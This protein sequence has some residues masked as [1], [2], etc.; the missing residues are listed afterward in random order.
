MLFIPEKPR[1][2]DVLNH[3]ASCSFNDP[4]YES[5]ITFLQKNPREILRNLKKNFP[6]ADFEQ[7]LEKAIQAGLIRRVDRRY[8]VQVTIFPEELA[9]QDI[10]KEQGQIVLAEILAHP[11]LNFK[12]LWQSLTVDQ[13]TLPLFVSD[14]NHLEKMRPWLVETKTFYGKFR[15]EEFQNGVPQTTLTNYFNRRYWTDNLQAI[16]QLLGE[17]DAQYFLDQAIP[18]LLRGQ[19]KPLRESRRDIFTEAL[20]LF[21]LLDSEKRATVIVNSSN[22][23]SSDSSAV[24]LFLEPVFFTSFSKACDNFQKYPPAVAEHLQL[25]LQG[26]ILEQLALKNYFPTIQVADEELWHCLIIEKQA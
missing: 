19:E 22:S 20:Q 7:K 11:K 15:L 2:N 6:Q 14:V 13:R 21:G 18:K 26:Y 4:L 12:Q 24:K 3:S 23:A 25:L 10:V 17:V 5:L 9:W 1:S 8:E 16:Q